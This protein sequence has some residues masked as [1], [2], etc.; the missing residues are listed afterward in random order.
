[1]GSMGSS[2]MPAR[3]EA[4]PATYGQA[5]V[6]IWVCFGLLAALLAGYLAVLVIR[7][8]DQSWAWLDNWGVAGFEIVAGLLCLARGAVRSR[9]RAVALFLGA[10]LICWAVGDIALAVESSGGATPPVPSVADAFYLAFYPLTYVAVVMFMRGELRR[11]TMPS[12]L[13]GAVAGL[14]AAAVCAAF[15]FHSILRSAGGDALGVATNLAYPVGDLLLLALVVGGTALLTGRRLA[16]WILLATG[17]AIN[18]AGDTFNLFGSTV[19]SSRIGVIVNGIAWPT[20]ILL[21]AMAVWIRPR[22]PDLVAPQRA[23]G[24]LL[25]GLAALAGLVV[26]FVGTV[27]HPSWVAIGLATATLITVGIRLAVSVRRLRILTEERH[28]QSVT[29]DLTGLWNRRYLTAMLDAFFADQ[30]D[31]Q[32]PDRQLAFLFVDLNRFKEIND[33]FGH[34]AGDDLLRQLGG[35]LSSSL[36]SSDALVRIGGD[37]FAVVLLDADAE[38]ATTIAERLSDRLDQPFALELVNARIGASIGIALAPADA[39]TGTELLWCADVA[40]YRAKLEDVPF[41]HY[42]QRLDSGERLVG[43]E[44]LRAALDDDQLVL[45]FQPQLDLHTGEITAVEALLRWAHPKLGLVPP[46]KFLPLAEEAG[47]MPAITSWVLDSA[48]KQCSAWRTTGRQISVSVTVS[49]TSLLDPG[50]AELIVGL[51]AD[52]RLPHEALVVEIT[53]T[54]VITQFERSKRVIRELRDLGLVVSIDDFGAGATS[55][56]YLSGLSVGELK[57][58]RTFISGITTGERERDRDRELVRATIELGHALGLRVV[59]EGIED[60]ATLDLLHELGCDVAQGYFISKPKPAS[61]LAFRSREVRETVGS[62]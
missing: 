36:R 1:M 43:V 54:N 21:M 26:L 28:R 47:L 27:T 10:A 48:L 44:E 49:A 50:F 9:G 38:F 7:P 4:L 18:V 13:D 23:T 16:P 41:A 14:G 53:E 30:A 25:P 6:A 2:A 51:L 22:P 15:A 34:A 59:A 46:L 8:P 31:P 37:E 60:R 20:A 32:M 5:R 33:T 62:G 45:H 3:R 42:D 29:D 39:R 57:L 12:W 24:F 61:E 35:R 19:G 52:H 58:D 11:L 55:L 56:A 40:M 17:I